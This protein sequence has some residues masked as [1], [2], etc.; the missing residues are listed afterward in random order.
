MERSVI[1]DD[2]FV[3]CRR[4]VVQLLGHGGVGDFVGCPM[5]HEEGCAHLTHVS[6]HPL[7][8][9]EAELL[10]GGESRR[11]LAHAQRIRIDKREAMVLHSEIKAVHRLRRSHHPCQLPRAQQSL[12]GDLYDVRRLDVVADKQHGRDGYDAIEEFWA[13]DRQAS[14]KAPAKGVA[15]PKQLQ[16]P[17]RNFGSHHCND[18]VQELP[19]QVYPLPP[20]GN[21]AK[22]AV[23]TS[24]TWQVGQ[25]QQSSLF[26]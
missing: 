17:R 19:N 21:V 4:H 7:G 25:H 3:G 22:Q 14:G 2:S 23:R 9:C 6:L 11:E 1:Q 5:Q 13:H 12:E 24:P 26:G 15:G 8:K 16:W 18:A 10:C 20:V